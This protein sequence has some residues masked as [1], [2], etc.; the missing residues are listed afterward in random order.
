MKFDDDKN[1]VMEDW[2]SVMSLEKS[3]NQNKA[4]QNGRN[5]KMKLSGRSGQ[6]D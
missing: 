3:P 5:K 2:N 4:Q 6:R 1:G